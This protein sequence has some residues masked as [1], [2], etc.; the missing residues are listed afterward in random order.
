[1]SVQADGMLI[2]VRLVLRKASVPKVV[3]DSGKSISLSDEQLLKASW[4]IRG[5]GEIPVF[6]QIS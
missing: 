4:P 2:S 3:S 1:M 6:S 5:Q